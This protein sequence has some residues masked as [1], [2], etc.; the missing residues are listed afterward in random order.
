MTLAQQCANAFRTQTKTV[1]VRTLALPLGGKRDKI[2]NVICW[3][4]PDGSVLTTVGR[5]RSHK[6][7]VRDNWS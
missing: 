5:G 7:K 1:S 6:M 2:I 3:N 4:F